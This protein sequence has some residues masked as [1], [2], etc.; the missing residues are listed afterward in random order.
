MAAIYFVF[1]KKNGENYKKNSPLT[2]I[3]LKL[4]DQKWLSQGSCVDSA[5]LTK[6]RIRKYDWSSQLYMQTS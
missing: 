1:Q 6:N 3:F 2:M 5:P 4:K